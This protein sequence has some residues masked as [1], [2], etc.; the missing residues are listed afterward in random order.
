MSYLIINLVYIFSCLFIYDISKSAFTSLLLSM[1]GVRKP[2]NHKDYAHH[3][4][5]FN[6]LMTRVDSYSM[7]Y[8]LPGNH[9][10]VRRKIYIYLLKQGKLT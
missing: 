7:F 10:Q 8:V 9:H 4:L 1:R 5:L 3:F 2:Y 6:F